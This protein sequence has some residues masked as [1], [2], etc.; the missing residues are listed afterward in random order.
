MLSSSGMTEILPFT[1]V[2]VNGPILT[3]E[4]PGLKLM[5]NVKWDKPFLKQV[6]D[7]GIGVD[8]DI[9]SLVIEC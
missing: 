5:G 2:A 9:F 1:V 8:T 3:G 6:T 4:S 7:D